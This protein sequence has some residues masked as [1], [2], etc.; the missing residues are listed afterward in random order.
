MS[1]GEAPRP[2]L[3]ANYSDLFD[4][5]P[6]PGFLVD[7]ETYEVIDVNPAAELTLGLSMEKAL[8]AQLSDFLLESD[9][10]GFA[11]ALR[12]SKRRYYLRKFGVSWVGSGERRISLEIVAC[13]LELAG[14]RKALQLICRDVTAEREARANE[15]RYLRELIVLNSKLE[16]LSTQ[17]EMTQLAN[18]RFFKQELHEEHERA[19]RYGQPYSIVFCDLD[20]FKRYNDQN[21]H[22]AGDELLRSFAAILKS[23]CRNLDLAARYGGEEFVV[24]CRSTPGEG[25]LVL[26]ERI[27]AKVAAY[28]FAFADKQPLGF[29]SVSIGVAEYGGGALREEDILKAA[30]EALYRSKEGGRNRVTRAPGPPAADCK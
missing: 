29:V 12:M 18:Y 24:L 28:P 20:H 26:A 5:M 3:I 2:S 11:K 13:V 16:A 10:E 7:A 27:R 25:A 8:G 19:E 23:E 1:E 14:G 9:R 21:G 17:D 30:D 22:P 6:D 4:R 15:E